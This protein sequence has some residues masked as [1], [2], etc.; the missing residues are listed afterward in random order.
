MDN[1][2]FEHNDTDEYKVL[3]LFEKDTNNRNCIIV[4]SIKKN[5]ICY[6]D[7]LE[8]EIKSQKFQPI[9]YLIVR[10]LI[11][12]LESKG[13]K[14]IYLAVAASGKR[15]YRLYELYRSMGFI[16]VPDDFNINTF[17]GYNKINTTESF[18][19]SEYALRAKNETITNEHRRT[20]RDLYMIN[21]GIMIGSVNH[22]KATLDNKIGKA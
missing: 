17:N 19:N 7:N 16:C 14:Y 5:S 11:N 21:C 2:Y 6:I 10:E 4:Y 1:F 3:E 12:I 9:S 15:F 20:L 18:L 13:I 8:C 22:I